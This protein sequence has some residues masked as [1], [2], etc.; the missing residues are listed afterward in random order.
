M[1]LQSSNLEVHL[2]TQ[3]LLRLLDMG[4]KVTKI[5]TDAHVQ[6]AVLKSKFHKMCLC[7]STQ[8]IDVNTT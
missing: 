2:F 3:G 6:I 4:V 5:V 8:K 7:D 1:N